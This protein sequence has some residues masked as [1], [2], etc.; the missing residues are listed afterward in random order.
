MKDIYHSKYL[1]KQRGTNREV[2]T[3]LCLNGSAYVNLA[4]NNAV[5]KCPACLAILELIDGGLSIQEAQSTYINRDTEEISV[6]T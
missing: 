5:V 1:R 2:P 3:P 4:A 6:P